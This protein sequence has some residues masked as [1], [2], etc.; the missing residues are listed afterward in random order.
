MTKREY[1]E[2]YKNYKPRSFWSFPLLKRI[3]ETR[4]YKKYK[5]RQ[6]TVI[7]VGCGLGRSLKYL[8]KKRIKS[9][10]VEISDACIHVLKKHKY[11]CIRARKKLRINF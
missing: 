3:F 2:I 6:K 10:G 7:D 1:A 11:K 4:K 9:I 5:L 8:R